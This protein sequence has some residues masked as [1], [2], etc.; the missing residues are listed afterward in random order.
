[1]ASVTQHS[2]GAAP[3]LL[4]CL[5]PFQTQSPGVPQVFVLGPVPLSLFILE[6]QSYDIYIYTDDTNLPMKPKSLH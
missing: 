6:A 3:S 1:M 5:S 2:P 4:T